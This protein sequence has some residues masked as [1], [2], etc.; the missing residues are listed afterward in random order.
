MK[1]KKLTLQT[2]YLNMINNIQTNKILLLIVI[3]IQEQQNH[4][5]E[6]DR[7]RESKSHV[8]S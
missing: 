1:T 3:N 8:L 7:E 4:W 2:Q 6:R 5:K